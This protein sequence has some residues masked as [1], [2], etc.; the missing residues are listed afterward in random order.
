MRIKPAFDLKDKGL[1]LKHKNLV[2]KIKA[3][4]PDLES[5]IFSVSFIN[6][7]NQNDKVN[8]EQCMLLG[9]NCAIKVSWKSEGF[10]ESL[11]LDGTNTLI[12]SHISFADG[13]YSDKRKYYYP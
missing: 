11:R 2:S 12:D 5:G 9:N 3:T 6:F 1:F 10:N 13:Y 8:N 7:L 4:Q